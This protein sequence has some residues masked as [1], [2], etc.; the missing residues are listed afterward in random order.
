MGS[1][2][3]MWGHHKGT[4]Q[5]SKHI[6]WI[7]NW[8][9]LAVTYAYTFILILLILFFSICKLSPIWVLKSKSLKFYFQAPHAE[10]AVKLEHDKGDNRSSDEEISMEES[11]LQHLENLTSQVVQVL[12]FGFTSVILWSNGQVYWICARPVTKQ[13]TEE[14]RICFRDSLYRLAGNSKHD[15]CQSRNAMPDQDSTRLVRMLSYFHWWTRV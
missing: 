6:F 9:Q 11:V 3:G 1:R 14:T 4:R 8:W 7:F 15:A 2:R 10:A 5:L 13:L 12:C